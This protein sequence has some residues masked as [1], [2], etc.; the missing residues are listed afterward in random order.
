[1]SA[2]APAPTRLAWGLQLTGGASQSEALSEYRELQKTYRSVLGSREPLVLRS[3]AGRNHFWYR[4][5]VAAAT[6]LQAQLLCRS[7]IAAGG[8]CIVQRN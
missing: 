4:V 8:S 5:R 6:R 2:V 1:L 3:K 7:L